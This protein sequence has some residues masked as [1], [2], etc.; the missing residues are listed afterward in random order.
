MGKERVTERG[1]AQKERE[2]KRHIRFSTR[3]H[4]RHGNSYAKK[5]QSR[6][7][8]ALHDE[9]QDGDA[10]DEKERCNEAKHGQ[11]QPKKPVPGQRQ[12]LP[13][14]R[15]IGGKK[16]DDDDLAKFRWLHG[17]RA[18]DDPVAAAA[19]LRAEKERR[20]QEQKTEDAQK[21]WIGKEAKNPL[22]KKDEEKINDQTEQQP[23][24]L[25]QKERGLQA[26]D[27]DEAETCEQH[28]RRE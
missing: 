23:A 10:P 21:I 17:E 18:E 8:I 2:G 1:C 11:L 12:H 26:S 27:H 9:H 6:A 5:E 25:C 15:Q 3:S 7:E 19:D 14:L 13:M 16:H 28:G 4:I 20:A 24:H 22:P